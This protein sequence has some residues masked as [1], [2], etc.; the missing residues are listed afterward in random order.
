MGGAYGGFGRFSEVSGRF[1][2]LSYRDPN[3]KGTLDAY[4]AAPSA[5]LD[6]EVTKDDILQGVIGAVGDLDSPQS[7]D[8]K[9]YISM[10][11]YMLGESLDSRQRWRNEILNTKTED[12]KKF[13]ERLKNVSKNGSVAVVGSQGALEEAN[14]QVEAKDKLTISSAF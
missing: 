7:P 4:D 12:F 3:L 11:R 10:V 1:V 13:A 5:I 9:G 8:Q 14:K 6:H 2:Y